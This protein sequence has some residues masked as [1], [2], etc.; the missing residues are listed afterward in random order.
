MAISKPILEQT[1]DEY[2]KQMSVNGKDRSKDSLRV[3]RA[4]IHKRQPVD[5]VVIC[6]K[7]IGEAFKKQGSGNLIITSSMS[8]QIVNVPTDQPVYNASKAFVTHFGK[9]LAR[10][11]RE[12]ARVN[13]VSPGFFDT[14]MGA[15]PETV[16]EAYRMSSVGRQGDVKE[17]KG[18][19]LYLAS[20]ASTY[21]TGSDV[22]ID[23]GY[24]LP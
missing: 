8:A 11:W 14:K 16:N 20:D 12:F 18:L 4:N 15:S 7:Y 13:I 2:R 5:G 6:A 21:M 10:E 1:L 17:I 19:Y 9:S 22:V 3:S 24:T 23:G